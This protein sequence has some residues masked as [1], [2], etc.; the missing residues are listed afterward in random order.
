MTRANRSREE[1]LAAS[2]H[3][4]YEIQMFRTLALAMA[5]GIS[6]QGPLNNALL[7]SFTVHTRA[8]LDFLYA[9]KPRPDDVIA[10]DFLPPDEWLAQ[11]PVKSKLLEGIHLRV[12]KEVAHLT[13][14]RQAVTEETKVWHF[15][16]IAKEVT[17]AVNKFLALVPRDL[18]GPRWSEQSLPT[19][20]N[21]ERPTLN[22]TAQPPQSTQPIPDIVGEK[23]GERLQNLKTPE[24]CE[25][26]MKNVQDKYPD[27]A[28][29]ARRRAVELRAKALS[30][31]SGYKDQ[32]EMELLKA[33]Y[34]YEEVLSE[35]NKR[36]TRASRTWQMINRHG[37]IRAAE[38][39]VD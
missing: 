26:F 15:A 12:G 18:L 11:R 39:A 23:V 31:K 28:R 5:S 27:L 24:E 20:A 3:L 29:E 32:V 8:L 7:E 1:L 21:G 13:Y 37:I 36:K 22:P 2:D 17:A 33:L 19:A 4:H 35:K 38:R 25:Q 16:Q 30:D 9:A 10:E 6:G 14:A 34:A